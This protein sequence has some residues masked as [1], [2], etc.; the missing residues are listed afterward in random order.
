MTGFLD[1]IAEDV[2]AE[3]SKASEA[4]PVFAVQNVGRPV[5]TKRDLAK[6]AE[7]AYR[8]NVIAFRSIKLVSDSAASVKWNLFQTAA[9]DRRAIE[10]HDLLKLWAKPN[11]TMG[12]SEYV[13]NVVGYYLIAGNSYL[14]AVGP[15]RKP[16]LELWTPRPDR[17]QVIAGRFG[18]PQGFVYKVGGKEKTWDADLVT[19]KSA[20]LH[21]KTFHPLD[22]WYGMSA[23]EAAARSVD[24]RN[25]ADD[26][27]NALIR[28][29]ARPSGAL[30][31]DPRDKTASDRL[32]DEQFVRLKAELEDHQRVGNTGQPMLLEGGLRWEQ[33]GLSPLDMDFLNAKNTS[34]RDIALAFGV[35]P[36]LLGIPGDSTFSNYQEARLAL[37]EETVIPLLRMLRD[38]LNGWLAPMFGDG[39]ELEPDLDDV[40]ALAL[41]RQARMEAFDGVSYLSIN[42]KL[43]AAGFEDVEG[44][45]II[46]GP[47][48]VIADGQAFV[49]ATL[50]P[51]G[52]EPE[53]SDED[54]EARGK[55]AIP[56]GG[57][58]KEA[59]EALHDLAYGGED[60]EGDEAT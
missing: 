59:A 54:D 14:E 42:Q 4:G 35:P 3:Q 29:G 11:P 24:L 17:M 57:M 40:P 13:Q 36:Q 37:W 34:S 31:Y 19:G 45:D 39:L 1:S 9:G 6:L 18:L 48:F 50:L 27:N 12:R 41:R 52:A 26:H 8:K 46:V 49:S 16:P 33:M 43:K 55:T 15:E 7:E 20:I 53:A 44:G 22:D 60:G 10:D 58:T 30:V 56:E 5:W 28:N 23:V 32:G 47:N 2:A 38:E 21:L 25:I 51:L